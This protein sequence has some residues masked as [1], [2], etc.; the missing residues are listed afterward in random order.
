[1][2][3]GVLAAALPHPPLRQGAA[4]QPS[5]GLTACPPHP[6]RLRAAP[7]QAGDGSAFPPSLHPAYL[8]RCREALTAGAEGSGRAILRSSTPV[9]RLRC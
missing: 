9:G 4:G 6:E 7:P 8:P 5:S 3:G 2:R 1:M